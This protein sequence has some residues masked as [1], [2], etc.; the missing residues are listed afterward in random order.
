MTVRFYATAALAAVVLLA[1]ACVPDRIAAPAP[2]TTLTPLQQAITA[3][4]FDPMGAQVE[5]DRV[6]VEGDIALSLLELTSALS[7][8]SR[9]PR[10]RTQ[11][12][13]NQTVSSTNVSSVTIDLTALGAFSAQVLAGARLALSDWN[14][15][16]QSGVYLTEATPGDIT[17][18]VG[19]YYDSYGYQDYNLFGV[20]S[21]P[22]HASALGK[23]GPTISVNR[24]FAYQSN[25]TSNA[26]YNMVHEI[27]HT[28]GFR[29]S[30]WQSTCR[31]T[32][33]DTEGAGANQIAGTSATD[34]A[35]VMNA[36]TA[37]RL[38]S[39]FSAGDLTAIRTLYPGPA[40]LAVTMSGTSVMANGTFTWTA[41]VTGGTA[42]YTYKWEWHDF[43][44]AE[45]DLMSSET[46][47][48]HTETLVSNRNAFYLRVTV[49]SPFKGQ[50]R[51]AQKLVGRPYEC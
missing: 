21:Y 25:V 5:G 1:S 31:G 49:T 20:G 47:P 19:S 41:N 33:V 38:W 17:V 3:R 46:G 14:A 36:C 2:S 40:N 4:G 39:A 27:G 6:I 24:F 11:W 32:E 22:M 51:S 10:I 30:N 42:P 23:P 37:A 45:W 48:T 50:S 15:V 7:D 29:H 35:S 44:D 13:T 12:S 8:T 43:C 26:R 18:T 9:G 16:N 34:A 28:L